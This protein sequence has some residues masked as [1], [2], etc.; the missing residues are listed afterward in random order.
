MIPGWVVPAV[1]SFGFCW[2][3]RRF[4]RHFIANSPLSNDWGDF[5][6]GVVFACF[7]GAVWPLMLVFV[8]LKFSLNAH[9]AQTLAQKIG[10][11]TREQKSRDKQRTR[12][13]SHKRL[14]DLERELNLPITPFES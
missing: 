13:E 12:M 1:Y 5:G 7:V 6:F 4:F 10:G 14:N 3:W 11:R 2:G 9:D 8:L